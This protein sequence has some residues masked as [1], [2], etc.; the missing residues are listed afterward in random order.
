MHR[1]SMK[2]NHHGSRTRQNMAGFHH[3]KATNGQAR[4]TRLSAFALLAICCIFA[5]GC[6]QGAATVPETQDA[7]VVAITPNPTAT[8]EPTA[9]P[10]PTPDPAMEPFTIAWLGDTQSYASTYPEQFDTMTKWVVDNRE[11]YNIQ[12]VVHTGDI[13]NEPRSAAEWETAQKALSRFNG[14]LPFFSVAGNHDLVGVLTHTG[15]D[16]TPYAALMEE[17]NCQDTPTLAGMEENWRRRYDLLT[18]GDEDFIFIGVGYGLVHADYDWLNDTLAKYPERTAVLIVHY[19]LDFDG[20]CREEGRH[21]FRRVVINN[22]N[23]KYV[24]CGHRH[25]V[26]HVVQDIDVDLDRK[27]DWN[28]YALMND[29][30]GY[31]KGGGGYLVLLTFDPKDREIR[32]TSYSPVLDDFNYFEDETIETYT[33]PYLTGNGPMPTPLPQ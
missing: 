33:L 18:I 6:G 25:R 2:S 8:Q 20:V 3:T 11:A 30:Q 29:Y 10:N 5:L 19:Y 17:L 12:Y 24:L 1:G 27:V 31:E 21:L 26:Q 7:A 9:T 16:Y 14:V 32:V 4:I 22:P 13:V 15:K 23:I 28:V